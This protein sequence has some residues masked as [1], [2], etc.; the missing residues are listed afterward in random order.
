M[1]R[2]FYARASKSG[3]W[4]GRDAKGELSCNKNF[5]NAIACKTAKEAEKLWAQMSKETQAK[6]NPPAW[7]SGEPLI[8]DGVDPGNAPPGL[9][10]FL[11]MCQGR[12]VGQKQGY[13][14]S[15]DWVLTPTL[16]QAHV[17]ASRD[18]ALSALL[19]ALPSAPA[20]SPPPDS[21]V[22]P[23]RGLFGAPIQ[24]PGSSADS[25]GCALGQAGLRAEL[26]EVAAPA[27]PGPRKTRKL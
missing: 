16:G 3:I 23:L 12:F 13:N 15:F 17:F 10:V 24:P 14:N 18:E 9:T 6:P 8:F 5:G 4:M 21:C 19:Y 7:A 27:A 22:L 20:G 25:L 2:V 11:A 1:P 26:G